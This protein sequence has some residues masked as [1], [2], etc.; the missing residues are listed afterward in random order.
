MKINIERTIRMGYGAAFLL[1]LFSYGLLYFISGRNKQMTELVMHSN[2]VIKKM[3]AVF[4]A[5]QDAETGFRGFLVTNDTAFLEP[6]YKGKKS[7]AEQYDS[8]KGYINENKPLQG[9][10]DTLQFFATEKFQVMDAAMRIYKRAG[11]ITD[12]I[13]ILSHQ[14]KAAMDRI[15]TAL[16]IMQV[17]EVAVL[18]EHKR[19]LDAQYNS[20]QIVTTISLIVAFI[21]VGYSVVT[22]NRENTAK[23]VSDSKALAYRLQL[24]ER[25]RELNKKN[26][27]LFQLRNIEKFA[28]T[29]RI[30]RTM[31]HEVKNPLNNINLATEHLK[32]NEQNT[33]ETTLMLDIINRNADRINQLITQL[34]NSTGLTDLNFQPASINELLDE[35]LIM[36]ADRIDLQNIKVVRKYATEICHVSVDKV[37]IKIAFLN[38]ILNAVEAMES[39]AGILEIQTEA[40]ND[41]CIVTITDNGYGMNEET[42]SKLFEPYFTSKANGTGLG[43][44][45]TQNIVLNHKGSLNVRSQPDHGTSFI[46]TLNFAG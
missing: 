28:A 46:I 12:S 14:G 41:K 32:D 45:N 44:T 15:R 26:S 22:Y 1:L 13:K 42:L 23:K 31:A 20:I 38:I 21:L 43:L 39:K 30:A 36:A 27:E 16:S 10:L 7:Y 3:T 40:K 29:G 8:L 5:L 9:Q 19:Q 2:N 37:T 34:L 18:A 25:I 17:T 11:Y 6:F 35:A 33:E 24:E 4:A